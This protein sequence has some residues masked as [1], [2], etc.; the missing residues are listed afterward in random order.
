MPTGRRPKFVKMVGPSQFKQE[1]GAVRRHVAFKATHWMQASSTPAQAEPAHDPGAARPVVRLLLESPLPLALAHGRFRGIF[2]PIKRQTCRFSILSGLS[3]TFPP[4]TISLA[5][6]S[7][8]NC[9]PLKGAMA[10]ND[11]NRRWFLSIL[12]SL[13]M[14]V[15]GFLVA[16]P[17]LGYFFAP[18]R[19]KSGSAEGGVHDAG[20]L[21]EILIG[22]WRLL[23]LEIVQEDGWR[24]TRGIG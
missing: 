14:L 21:S 3:P 1:P 4:D 13:L 6:S 12:T 17:A 7:C 15:I 20:P 24:K 22:Q 18:L 8:K 2:G 16:I 5:I 9:F 11:R 19:R 23:S 10:N